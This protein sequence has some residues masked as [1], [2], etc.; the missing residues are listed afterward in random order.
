[1]NQQHFND[2][3]QFFTMSRNPDVIRTQHQQLMTFQ[4]QIKQYPDL[5]ECL[6]TILTNNQFQQFFINALLFL[7]QN[8]HKFLNNLPSQ[9]LVTTLLPFLENN[10]LRGPASNVISCIFTVEQ[11]PFQMQLMQLLSTTL[12]NQNESSATEGALTLLDMIF[13]DFIRFPSTECG[14]QVLPTIFNLLSQKLNS[15][16]E[17]IRILTMK[18]LLTSSYN[19]DLYC[20]MI[21]QIVQHGLDSSSEIRR[22]AI[23]FIES[24]NILYPDY[25][26]QYSTI[27]F[28]TLIKLLNDN[29][30]Q[31]RMLTYSVW[32]TM[33]EVMTTQMKPYLQTILPIILPRIQYTQSIINDRNEECCDLIDGDGS[34]N[35]RTSIA[36]TL[37]IMALCYSND[38][39]QLLLPLID[40]LISSNQQNWTSIESGIF[41]FG[42]IMN[43]GWNPTDH[44]L[45]NAICTIFRKIM[46][47]ISFANPFVQETVVWTLSRTIDYYEILYKPEDLQQLYAIC[48][49]ILVKSTPIMK[50]NALKILC[51][52]VEANIPSIISHSQELLQVVLNHF[53][54]PSF[55]GMKIMELI[56]I[57]ADF[58]EELF[59]ENQQL[60]AEC[61]M[62]FLSYAHRHAQTPNVMET[63]LF[64]LSY[65]LPRFGNIA[66]NICGDL[67]KMM[68]QIFPTCGDDLQF[69]STCLFMFD[70]IIN[71]DPQY[72]LP[73][74]QAL[75]PHMSLYLKQMHQEMTKASY[76]LLGDL[77]LLIPNEISQFIP[78]YMESIF[79]LM[80]FGFMDYSGNIYW[81]LMQMMKQYKQNMSVFSERI[82]KTIIT[83]IQK[84]EKIKA[85]IQVS[86]FIVLMQNIEMNPQIAFPYV[87][88]ICTKLLP[89]YMPDVVNISLFNPVLLGELI[90]SNVQQC[91]QGITN[92]LSFFNQLLV[93]VN[94]SL[95]QI[96]EKVRNA[97]KNT[98][99]DVK[100][101]PIWIA[102]Q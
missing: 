72:A 46:P 17:S 99:N 61:F 38:F 37:E 31:N 70:T 25:I 68:I 45:C 88:F 20:E 62:K 66:K 36:K 83:K 22:Y 55:I 75:S 34:E 27:V 102:Y 9:Q 63:S 19:V 6:L 93:Q 44:N 98:F 15:T 5:I 53:E 71:I 69:T 49:Q 89:R 96:T 24:V 16:N 58:A 7:R 56:T 39:I 43:E 47:L 67:T 41:I 57:I 79:F 2:L 14:K 52:L 80:E 100:Y 3:I 50:Y 21:P 51:C 65:I 85:N 28:E 94:P 86:M 92:I 60:L 11:T 77:I 26:K 40:N 64:Q 4:D 33:C 87:G 59:H 48:L 84:T 42:C 8:I 78:Q 10:T 18:C 73:I 74:F 1:M 82:V 35:E 91:E 54:D 13:E 81:C 23:L 101:Q 12:N 95:Q 76:S 90:C 29:N 97:L 32:G 30:S